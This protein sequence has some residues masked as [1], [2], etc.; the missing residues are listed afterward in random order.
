[1]TNRARIAAIFVAVGFGI[2]GCHYAQTSPPPP[3]PPPPPPQ[4][5]EPTCAT[6]AIVTYDPADTTYPLRVSAK[7]IAVQY[8]AQDAS[9][10]AVCWYL[11]VQG[12]DP[13]PFDQMK[14]EGVDSVT[15]KNGH[16]VL[17]GD[18]NFQ[19]KGFVK[20]FFCDEPNWPP[21]PNPSVTIHYSVIGRLKGATQDL[22]VD[23]DIIIQKK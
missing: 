12:S 15:G 5:S 9:K 19:G 7:P 14:L 23:P 2:L 10:W 21:G 8:P 16:R 20:A 1:M 6:S 3:A 11:V 13:D 4:V 18:T 17:C 22:A